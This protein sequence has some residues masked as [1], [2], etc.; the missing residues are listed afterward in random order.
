MSTEIKVF[1]C[2]DCD[3]VAKL[4]TNLLRHMERMHKIY[5]CEFCDYNTIKNANLIRHIQN[6][7][8]NES[9]PK[10]GWFF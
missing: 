5:Q 10:I 9:P 1:Q 2:E 8:K 3:Y 7:H 6:K 4:K